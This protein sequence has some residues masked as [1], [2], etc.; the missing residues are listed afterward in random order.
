MYFI[1]AERSEEPVQNEHKYIP[2][3][4][5]AFKKTN[6]PLSNISSDPVFSQDE[7]GAIAQFAFDKEPAAKVLEGEANLCRESHK[8]CVIRQR[9]QLE[10]CSIF[11]YRYRY[12]G[13]EQSIFVNPAHALV[14][15]LAGPIQ[16]AI[17]TTDGQAQTA[18]DEKRYEDAFRLNVK[19]LC[20]EEPTLTQTGLRQAI[21]KGLSKE[22]HIIAL[23]VGLALSLLWLFAGPHITGH[24]GNFGGF[25]GILSAIAAVELFARDAALR[26]HQTQ[27]RRV[28]AALIGL[29]AFLAAAPINAHSIDSA[30]DLIDWIPFAFFNLALIVVAFVRAKERSRRRQIEQHLREFENKSAIE[31][32]I[33][34]FDKPGIETNALFGLCLVVFFLLIA[35]VG[36]ALYHHQ[37]Q[38]ISA[39]QVEQPDSAPPQ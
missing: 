35:D 2:T 13:K 34:D 36:V 37:A 31:A 4:F 10:R 12:G 32:Y 6:N 26:F 9:L 23:P 15:D 18:F 33:I 5:P 20:M 19:A 38:P 14:E 3:T 1:S 24:L 28:I 11:E 30:A 7:P 27:F 25:L 21:F 16:A 8:G 39:I 22:Y 29:A 17:S